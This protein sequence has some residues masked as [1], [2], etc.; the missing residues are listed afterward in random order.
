MD[1]HQKWQFHSPKWQIAFFGRFFMSWL[2]QLPSPKWQK[3]S[4]KWQIHS[5]KWHETITKMTRN[6]H[7]NCK[8]RHQNCKFVWLIGAYRFQ[9]KVG[10]MWKTWEIPGGTPTL[11]RAFYV[12]SVGCMQNRLGQFSV[13]HWIFLIVLCRK[14]LTNTARGA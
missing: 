9:N 1:R 6:H 12:W 2:R 14:D 10:T 4:P 7:E 13:N 5:P 11:R 3:T 8:K